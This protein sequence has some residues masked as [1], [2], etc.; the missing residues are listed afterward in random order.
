MPVFLFAHENGGSA[1]R[2]STKSMDLITGAGYALVSWESIPSISTTAHVD[3]GSADAQLAFDW[4]QANA[5]TYNFDPDTIV[6]GGRSRGSILSWRLGHSRHEAIAGLYFY[7]ALPNGVWA[8]PDVWNPLNDVTA[9][10]PPL[11]FAYGPAPNDGDIHNPVNVYPVL[12]RYRELGMPGWV[13]LTHSMTAA[14][15]DAFNFFPDFVAG[16]KSNRSRTAARNSAD[17]GINTAV[18][19]SAACFISAFAMGLSLSSWQ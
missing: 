10:S 18:S 5:A 17:T 15:L 7:N 14:R 2:F 4:V 9:D 6:V 12:D 16:L 8:F 19:N 13:N 1:D 3:V 11:Y